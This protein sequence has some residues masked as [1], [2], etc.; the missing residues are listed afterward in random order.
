MKRFENIK[1]RDSLNIDVELFSEV[2]FSPNSIIIY[3]KGENINRKNFDK[4]I[5]Y[6]EI[7]TSLNDESINLKYIGYLFRFFIGRTN[8]PFLLKFYKSYLRSSII[9]ITNINGVISR[10][11]V[12]KTGFLF[13]TELVSPLRDYKESNFKAI[14]YRKSLRFISNCYCFSLTDNNSTLRSIDNIFNRSIQKQ[15]SKEH[16]L[17]ESIKKTKLVI[18]QNDLNKKNRRISEEFESMKQKREKNNIL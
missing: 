15:K 17:K 16:E 6:L 4:I 2:I 18:E 1:T 10:I 14:I 11:I 8:D 5:T 13:E 12:M 7:Q 3:N 9:C